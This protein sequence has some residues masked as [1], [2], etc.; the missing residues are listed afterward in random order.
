MAV[1]QSMFCQWMT[2]I[3]LYHPS[4][5]SWTYQ[6]DK[7]N[8]TLKATERY[9]FIKW[10]IT[11]YKSEL[12]GAVSSVGLLGSDAYCQNTRAANSWFSYKRGKR[13]AYFLI[14]YLMDDCIFFN[15]LS[16]WMMIKTRLLSTLPRF[17][18]WFC[19]L[20]EILR[21]LK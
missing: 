17:S 21:A 16:W 5:S 15:P 1:I 12:V 7:C 19:P 10:K 18:C 4:P 14:P 13:F 8:P 3:K 9:G 6:E 2:G 11:L 20:K